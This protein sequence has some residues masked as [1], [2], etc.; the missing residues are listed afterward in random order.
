MMNSRRIR[1]GGILAETPRRAVVRGVMAQAV[2]AV[3][4]GAEVGVDEPVELGTTRR[5]VEGQ[6]KR[7]S[8]TRSR[9]IQLWPRRTSR[10][11]QTG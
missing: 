3:E 11:R 9:E 7:A 10:R 8:Y 5:L 6:V 2:A 4:V 1:S